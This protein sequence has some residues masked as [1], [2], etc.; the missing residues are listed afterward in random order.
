MTWTEFKAKVDELLKKKGISEK[1][2]IWYIDVSFP[3]VEDFEKEH[4]GVFK[5]EHCGIAIS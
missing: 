3:S 1:T 4:V 2:K 5:D